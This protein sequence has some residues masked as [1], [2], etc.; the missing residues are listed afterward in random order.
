MCHSGWQNAFVHVSIYT[1]HDRVKLCQ[2]SCP[3]KNEIHM[4]FQL[5]K[6]LWSM[7]TGMEWAEQAFSV[8]S[9]GSWAWVWSSSSKGM[10][11]KCSVYSAPVKKCTVSPYKNSV[12]CHIVPNPQD[13]H[14]SLKLKIF[15]MKS[16]RFLSLNWQPTQQPVSGPW[17]NAS[18][19]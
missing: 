4:R 7:H 11:W 6:A 1:M 3:Q 12:I 2:I 5:F 16:K 19:K 15:L 17:V 9:Y 8:H 18:L 14:S 13:F 10:N